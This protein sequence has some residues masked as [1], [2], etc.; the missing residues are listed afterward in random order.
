MEKPTKEQFHL[1]MYSKNNSI[2]FDQSLELYLKEYPEDIINPLPE[3]GSKK[4]SKNKK[5]IKQ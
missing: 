5:K 3:P 2:T 4:E 1:A